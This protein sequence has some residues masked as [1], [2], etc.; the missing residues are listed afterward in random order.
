MRYSFMCRLSYPLHT[1]PCTV[2]HRFPTALYYGP[3]GATVLTCSADLYFSHMQEPLV[4]LSTEYAIKIDG[5]LT[6]GN[7][8]DL[9]DKGVCHPVPE[10]N[11]LQTYFGIFPVLLGVTPFLPPLSSG[12]PMMY[13]FYPILNGG[14]CQAGITAAP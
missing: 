10:Q 5:G 1:K 8:T 2:A 3:H 13:R 9:K 6:T 14:K 4:S 12:H 11:T 7:P